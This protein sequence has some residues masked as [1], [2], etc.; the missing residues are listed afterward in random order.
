MGHTQRNGG[1]QIS[2]SS[3]EHPFRWREESRLTPCSTAGMETEAL[4]A[5]STRRWGRRSLGRVGVRPRPARDANASGQRARLRARAGVGVSTEAEVAAARSGQVV[6]RERRG[7]SMHRGG[8]PDSGRWRIEA[9]F[10]G[11]ARGVVMW[12]KLAEN[13]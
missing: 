3:T 12:E 2:Q 9:Y 13:G 11:S 4:A 10:S 1:T 7:T 5:S 8:E 6:D